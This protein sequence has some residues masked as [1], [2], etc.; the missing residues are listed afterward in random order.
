MKEG[1]KIQVLIPVLLLSMGASIAQGQ[2]LPTA[3]SSMASNLGP[4]LP[5]L[6]GVFHYSLSASEVIQFG[7]YG[8]GNTTN[9]TDFSGNAAYTSPNTTR[10]FSMLFSGG[11]A[12]AD[13]S[14]GGT[15][16]F[17]SISA[18]QGYVTRHWIFNIS[19]SFSFLPQS[20][21]TGLSGIAGVGDLGIAPIQGPSEGPAGGVLSVSGNRVANGLSGSVERQ[22]TPATSISGVG[23]WSI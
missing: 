6:D 15:Q 16:S 21:T 3:E 12:I 1:M 10:P 2:A 22:I 9:A 23:S 18:S 11:V 14:A 7:Y 13:Q 5:N 20:P 4:N 8:S 19:D 17:W